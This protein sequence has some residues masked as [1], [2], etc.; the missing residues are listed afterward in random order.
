MIF[1]A[2]DMSQHLPLLMNMAMF[3]FILDVFAAMLK[4]DSAPAVEVT[5]ELR[6]RVRSSHGFRLDFCVLRFRS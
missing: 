4:L 6:G 1:G 3:G 5:R 2:S